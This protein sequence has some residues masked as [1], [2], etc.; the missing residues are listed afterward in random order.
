MA[1]LTTILLEAII[2]GLTLGTSCLITCLPVLVAHIAADH[3]GLK[4]GFVTTISFSF[5][6]L[7]ALSIYAII[8]GVVGTLLEE[9]INSTTPVFLIFSLIM[10]I[11]LIVYGLSLTIGQERFP[12]FSKKFCSFTE[13]KYSSFV[14]GILVGLFPCGPM[15]YM[16]GQA[17]LLGADSIALSFLFFLLFWIGTNIYLFIAGLSIG[18][19]A[20]YIRRHERIERIKWIAGLILIILGI[21]H[22]IQILNYI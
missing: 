20:E 22:F 7:V 8:F 21:F 9:F 10:I 1:D 2:L 14:L 6:R 17:L 15:F 19:G 3:P 12:S 13:R 11:F 18:G 16:F 4:N 5:G